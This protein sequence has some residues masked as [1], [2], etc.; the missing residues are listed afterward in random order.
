MEGYI[1]WVDFLNYV[2][3]IERIPEVNMEVTACYIMVALT[4]E[5]YLE[6]SCAYELSRMENY[7]G[8]DNN[9]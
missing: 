5:I 1:N 2:T 7:L 8:K 4:D 9:W 6:P 3:C